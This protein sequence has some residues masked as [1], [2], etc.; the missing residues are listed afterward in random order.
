[1]FFFDNALILL[2]K[3]NVFLKQVC[4]MKHFFKYILILLFLLKI[5]SNAL[6]QKEIATHSNAWTNYFGN[7][8]LT[9]KWGIHSEYQWRRNDF[10]THWQQSLLRFGIEYY[11]NAETTLTLGYGLIKTYPYG[12]QP[13]NHDVLEN[14]IWQQLN[15]K[16]K[17][18]KVEIFHRYRFEQ[19][20]LDNWVVYNSLELEQTD[21]LFRQRFRYRFLMN[22]PINNDEMI[23][24]TFFINF[25][26]ELFIGFGKGISTNIFDQN[27]LSS[28]IGWKMNKNINFQVGYLN[29]YIQKSDGLKQERN[30]TLI[31]AFTYNLDFR[32]TN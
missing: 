22:L 1:V 32:K 21:D 24:N 18:G 7:H 30:H 12:N 11:L 2:M 20:F 14:R 15:L 31:T 16:N 26:N 27:R 4:N 8:R 29:Q 25:N 9:D 5:S 23:D 10:Y 3:T 13:I 28:S 19:R 6:A 17:I